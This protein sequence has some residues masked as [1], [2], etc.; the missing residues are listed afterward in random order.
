MTQK[1]NDSLSERLISDAQDSSPAFSE[2]LHQRTMR[3]LRV[4]QTRAIVGSRSSWNHAIAAAAAA[5]LL[6]ISAWY[7]AGG[8]LPKPPQLAKAEP[9]VGIDVGIPD[10]GDLLRKGSEPLKH[11]ISG[12]EG[13]H[14]VQFEEDAR[15]LARYL[16][17]QLPQSDPRTST[18]REQPM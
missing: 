16:A 17:S 5:L 7:Y 13:D 11:V 18:K 4:Q 9:I 2:R 15:S 12:I 6:G 10:A 1:H 14:F 3:A 8:E